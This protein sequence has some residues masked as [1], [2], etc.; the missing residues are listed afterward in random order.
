MLYLSSIDVLN[1]NKSP[2][3]K[4]LLSKSYGHESIEKLNQ[5]DF[6][7]LIVQMISDLKKAINESSY[8][9][10]AF[11]VRSDPRMLLFWKF[12]K[13]LQTSTNLKGLAF[14]ISPSDIHEIKIM[15]RNTYGEVIELAIGLY[16]INCELEV[17]ELIY[18]SFIYF[19]S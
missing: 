19:E 1:V 9:D 7:E 17:F 2:L 6:N 10:V 15:K 3:T 12:F 4:A 16:I 11:Q 5:F 8:E 14:R 13:N 18:Q